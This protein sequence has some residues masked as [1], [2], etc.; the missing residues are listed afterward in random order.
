MSA[1][2]IPDKLRSQDFFHHIDMG[3]LNR[4]LCITALPGPYRTFFLEKQKPGSDHMT[5]LA[6]DHLL[7]TVLLDACEAVGAPTLL[8]A[9]AE[10]KPKQLF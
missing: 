1:T 8:Q 9:L 2:H 7:V 4:R 5:V 3:F 10:G 6:N